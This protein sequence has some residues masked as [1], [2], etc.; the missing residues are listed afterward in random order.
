MVDPKRGLALFV[1]LA[2]LVLAAPAGAFERPPELEQVASYFAGRPAQVRCPS[3]DEW[4]G[5]RSVTVGWAYT[6]LREDWI[7]LTR[8]SV[9]AR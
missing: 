8:R 1:L 5:D 7:M 4:R 3:V 6:H 9:S 2:S